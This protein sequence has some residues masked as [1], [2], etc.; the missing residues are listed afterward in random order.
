MQHLILCHTV[1]EGYGQYFARAVFVVRMVKQKWRT[2]SLG[3]L[4]DCEACRQCPPYPKKRKVS[5]FRLVQF[6]DPFVI[7][8]R[9]SRCN[10]YVAVSYCWPQETE[11]NGQLRP[12]TVHMNMENGTIR[13]NRAPRSVI[14]RVVTFAADNNVRLIWID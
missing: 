11:E 13:R 2:V 3:R 7:P 5:Q 6:R 8:F 14:D 4:V 1:L 9:P 12:Y 10:H